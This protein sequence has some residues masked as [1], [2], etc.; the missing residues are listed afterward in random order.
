MEPTSCLDLSRKTPEI[1]NPQ[2]IGC[3]WTQMWYLTGPLAYDV[4]F[5]FIK[6]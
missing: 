4:K 5:V 2:L 6:L 1:D 3:Q